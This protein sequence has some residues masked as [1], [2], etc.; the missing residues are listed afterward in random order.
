VTDEVARARVP[1]S[2]DGTDGSGHNARKITVYFGER[3]PGKDGGYAADELLELFGRSK[4]ATSVLLRGV[5]GFGIRHHLRTDQSLSLSED[6]PLVAVAVDET[7]QVAPLLTEIGAMNIRGL[8][9]I[10]RARLVNAEFR[11][12]PPRGAL[13]EGT[14]EATKLTVYVG[15]QDRVVRVPAFVAV[16][17][18]LHRRGLA[19]ATVFLGVDGTS[20]GSRE[21]ARFFDR[22]ADVPV[23]IIAVGS[24]ERI[25]AV[26]PELR[27]LLPRPSI[28]LERVRVCKRDGE[29]IARPHELPSVDDDGLALWQKIMV[30]TSES[31]LYHGS[32]IHRELIARLRADRVSSGA[33]ALRGI[34]GFHG[35][36][37]PHG[38]RLLQLRRRVPVTTVIIDKP[39][40]INRAFDVVDEL[41]AG[42]GL[43]TSEMVPAL[44]STQVAQRRGGFRLA[45]HRY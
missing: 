22:N 12:L 13:V 44:V 14:D 18:L 19:G 11:S 33:T 35:D 39:D 17:D 27:E 1:S 30:Y 9:T 5:A 6:P 31:T 32:P 2:G 29:L 8:V 42:H 4:I 10:E 43:V 23:M 36:H 3:T 40:R 28:T 41:T 37:Q 15:R 45:R 34:W 7:E 16:C 25:G 21:R 24:G 26:M 38:D 20:R